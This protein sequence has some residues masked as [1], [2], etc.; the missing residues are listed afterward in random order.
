MNVYKVKELENGDIN[1]EKVFIDVTKY[2]PIEKNNGDILL[3]KKIVLNIT[4]VNDLKRYDFKK[5]NITLCKFNNI[6]L[7]KLNFKY[8]LNNDGT[9]NN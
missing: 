5:S 3:Q 1:L 7:N 9:K 6:G 8:I 4:H 2:T